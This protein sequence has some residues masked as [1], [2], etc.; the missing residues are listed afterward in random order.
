MSKE[1][2]KLKN[3]DFAYGEFSDT[4]ST[5]KPDE[6]NIEKDENKPLNTNV[7]PKDQPVEE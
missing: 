6:K 3:L 5:Q 7:P 2:P 1:N 4:Q